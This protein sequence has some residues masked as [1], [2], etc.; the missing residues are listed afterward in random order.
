MNQKFKTVFG[1]TVALLI[2]SFGQV[3]AVRAESVNVALNK[4]TVASSVRDRPE[5]GQFHPSEYAVDGIWNTKENRWLVGTVTG[6][7][8]LEIDLEG[9]FTL[10][11]AEV[12]T[13]DQTSSSSFAVSEFK[14]QYLQEGEWVDIPGASVV[15]NKEEHVVF[16]FDQPI[17]TDQ[18][19]FYSDER[20]IIRV[21][22]IIVYGKPVN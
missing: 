17:V 5:L 6:P 16:A 13:G 19:R 9:V 8:W 14:L 20:D 12:W 11:S 7:H 21:A 3:A 18:V 4:P 22:E 15:N 10:D 2:A 1:L